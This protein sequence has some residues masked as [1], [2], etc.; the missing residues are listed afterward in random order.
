M[1]ESILST[2]RDR[3]VE[4]LANID[5]SKNDKTI[6]TSLPVHRTPVVSADNVSRES[7]TDDYH[8]CQ[9]SSGR[10]SPELD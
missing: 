10:L 1:A 9:R 3:L 8:S 6:V 5:A 4:R 2:T 7:T